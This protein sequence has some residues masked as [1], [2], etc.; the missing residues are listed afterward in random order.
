MPKTNRNEPEMLLMFA[1]RRKNHQTIHF[2]RTY[3][4]V[5]TCT[6]IY[7]HRDNASNSEEKPTNVSNVFK[8]FERQPQKSN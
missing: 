8:R 2:I 6:S 1:T 4:D 5:H 7:I 3:F